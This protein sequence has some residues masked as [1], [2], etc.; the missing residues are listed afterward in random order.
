MD[1][2]YVH[3]STSKVLGQIEQ[4]RQYREYFP[5]GSSGFNGDD[6]GTDDECSEQEIGGGES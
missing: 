3:G 4:I 2:W 5:D 6:D 1:C